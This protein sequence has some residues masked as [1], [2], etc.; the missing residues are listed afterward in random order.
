MII[1]EFINKKKKGLEHTKYEI[2]EFIAK[3]VD[4]KVPD[5]QVAAW[6]MAVNF[7]GM[8]KNEIVGLTDVM[9]HSGE[10]LDL[11]GTE[12]F[13]V[14]K[15]STGGVGDKVSIILAPLAQSAGCQVPMISGRG[16]GHTGGTLDKLESIPG[17]NVNLTEQDFANYIKQYG[18][19]MGGQ[20]EKL[21]PADS[22]L[23]SL[24][25]VTATVRSIPLITASILS[26]KIAEDIDGLVM[27][28]KTG[29][30]SFM[31][32]LSGSEE[33]ANT[34]KSVGEEFDLDIKAIITDMNQPLGKAV[35]NWLEVKE[36]IEVLD[37]GGPEDLKEV[38]LDL[39]AW[40]VVLSGLEKNYTKAKEKLQEKLNNG[41]A[42]ERF[43]QMIENQGGDSSYIKNPDKYKDPAHIRTVSSQEEGFVQSID[44]YKVGMA[45]VELGA[46]R[47]ELGNEIYPEVGIVFD[48]KIGDYVAA[49]EHICEIH[50][51]DQESFKRAREK[52]LD[53]F[54][55]GENKV[56]LPPRIYDTV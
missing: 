23:Y 5:Y 16:L 18:L 52:I 44:T 30:G 7:Q 36:C 35:G 29:N 47:L 49:T 32:E 55:I 2:K 41:E 34:L 31:P 13:K 38:T 46:G 10:T 11:S 21:V 45:G 48:K 6:L 33:L 51:R 4:G 37:G 20:T 26:K 17:F 14:D 28:V 12:G 42:K 43:I 27:D 25:D 3:Y 9:V 24:R 40:M 8:T 53:A 15:H 56:D 39:T 19:A 22:K 50:T 54:E 1:K